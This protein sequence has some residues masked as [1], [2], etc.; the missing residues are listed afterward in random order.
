MNLPKIKH[1]SFEQAKNAAP[2]NAEE[3][4]ARPS[5]RACFMLII[6]AVIIMVFVACVFRSRVLG[7]AIKSLPAFGSTANVTEN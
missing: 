6:V 3:K 5:P 1:L 2:D 4:R 7:V